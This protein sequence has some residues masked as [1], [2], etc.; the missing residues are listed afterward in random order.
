M[1]KCNGSKRHFTAPAE[2]L[3]ISL[4]G[5]HDFV[6]ALDKASSLGSHPTVVSDIVGHKK[7]FR[8]VFTARY[9][10]GA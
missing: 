8:K 5:C 9:K 1:A 2:E 4:I 10:I 7:V 6:N 3:D